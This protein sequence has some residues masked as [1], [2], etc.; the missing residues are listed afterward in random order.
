MILRVTPDPKKI[1]AERILREVA[2]VGYLA[3]EEK[4]Q[5][6]CGPVVTNDGKY[7]VIDGDLILMVSTFA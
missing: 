1:H 4:L 6:V 3:R 7:L 2:F 5:Y